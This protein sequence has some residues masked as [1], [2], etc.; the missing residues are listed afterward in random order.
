MGRWASKRPK[1][2]RRRRSAVRTSVAGGR[3]AG[4]GTAA[5][6]GSAAGAAAESSA[7]A[8]GRSA[9][10]RPWPLA[11]AA[12]ARRRAPCGTVRRRGDGPPP[13][14]ARAPGRAGR[15]L[16]VQRHDGED[17]LLLGRT[18]S[19]RASRGLVE[20]LAAHGEARRPR[21]HPQVC[22]AAPTS[23]LTAWK[24]KL[25]YLKAFCQYLTPSTRN[26][27]VSAPGHVAERLADLAGDV[28][29]QQRLQ[30]VLVRRVVVDAGQHGPAR[31]ADPVDAHR[32]EPA[33]G[34]GTAVPVGLRVRRQRLEVG[35]GLDPQPPAHQPVPVAAACRTASPG[36]TR[37]PRSPRLPWPWPARVPGSR[38]TGSRRRAAAACPCPGRTWSCGGRRTSRGRSPP[39]P[40]GP[41]PA[42]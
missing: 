28:A 2:L 32:V 21:P 26:W 18:P 27:S 16:P 1:L 39:E 5:R 38:R 22:A 31:P 9:A 35:V 41:G 4:S 3:A 23:M 12:P 20:P 25:L 34:R 33:A 37:A 14:R 8:A 17:A 19:S 30:G 11:S 10:R 40:S 36:R 24:E 15:A 29:G 6:S 13:C 7:P 42:A